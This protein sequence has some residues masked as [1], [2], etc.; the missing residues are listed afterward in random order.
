MDANRD[1]SDRIRPEARE[2]VVSNY[3]PYNAAV[4]ASLAQ[5][6][7]HAALLG[8]QSNLN[9]SKS[10]LLIVGGL[11]ILG[12]TLALIFWLLKPAAPAYFSSESSGQSRELGELARGEGV[13]DFEISTSFT[14]FSTTP[15]S[16][17]EI[18][19]TGKEYEPDDLSTPSNQYCYMTT[20][21]DVRG[22]ETEIAYVA[23]GEILL[24]TEDEYLI[25]EAVPLCQ[26]A[27]P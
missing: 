3:E 20:S 19:V 10:F 7:A 12:I 5:H 16:A 8:R 18:V 2:Y 13:T 24:A 26:F 22:A 11:S 1:E 27:E 14:V 15:T 9:A 23:D 6:R 17:G 4:A 25:R 21:D